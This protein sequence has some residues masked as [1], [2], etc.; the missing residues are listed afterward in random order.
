MITRAQQIQKL[1]DTKS[2]D[3]II[4]GGGASGLGI[5]VDAASRGFKTVLFEGNDFAKGTSSK[6]TKLVHGGVRYLAQGNIDLVI[7]ALEERGILAKNANHLFKNLS[8]IIPNYKWWQGYYYLVGLKIYDYLSKKMS[9]G[10]SILINSEK[11][12]ALLPN[13]KRENLSSGVIYHDGQFD[14]SRLAINLAQT[15]IEQN[16]TVL[17]YFKVN[18]ILKDKLGKNEGVTVVDKETEITYNIKSKCIINATGIFTDKILKK[19]DPTHKKTVIPSRGIHLV[20][21]KSFLKSDYGIMIPKTSDGRVLFIIPWYDKVLVGT[22]DTPIREKTLDPVAT[23]S[24]I[25][26]ILKNVKHYLNKAPK[27]KDILS[28]F[29]GLRPLAAP[30]EDDTKTKEVSRSHKIIVSKSSLISIIG[31][32]WTTYRKMAE[33]VVNKSIQVQNYQMVKSKTKDL[34]IHGNELRTSNSE[35]DYLAVYGSDTKAIKKLEASSI[36]YSQKIHVNFNF[37]VAQIIWAIREEMA[38]SVE[39][40]LARRT[41]LLFLDARSALEASPF[42]AKIMAD[43]LKKDKTWIEEQEAMFKEVAESY[44]IDYY[45]EMPIN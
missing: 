42:V 10:K 31:G 16:A 6:S 7:E 21:D 39:D 40:V 3:F 37:T 19:N 11:T 41:R 44:V 4:I 26:F 25:D 17:N 2:W 35:E 43:E 5:A 23:K 8:F 9:L 28:V 29:A 30:K 32:K 22:T 20:L 12:L 45:Y 15:A 1:E 36:L 18:S 38:R 33:D 34:H 14:D 27:K 24:E 13:L